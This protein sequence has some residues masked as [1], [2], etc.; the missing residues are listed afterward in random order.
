MSK[1]KTLSTSRSP[2]ARDSGRL[3]ARVFWTGRSQAVRLPKEMRFSTTEVTVRREGR[4]IILEPL[5]VKRDAKGWPLDFWSL[6]GAAPEFNVGDRAT[7]HERPD[8]LRP[9]R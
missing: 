7:P 3:R 8:P 5:E 2:A 4:A 9:R 6:A 1:R